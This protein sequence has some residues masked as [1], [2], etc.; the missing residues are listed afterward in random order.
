MN[1]ELRVLDQ[2]DCMTPDLNH[3]HKF[4][5]MGTS[6]FHLHGMG[7]LDGIADV[8]VKRYILPDKNTARHPQ[9]SL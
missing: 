5:I 9:S 1:L 3:Q 6:I 7:R 4:S 8:G 2:Y